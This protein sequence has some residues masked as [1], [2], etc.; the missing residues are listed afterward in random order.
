MP[1]FTVIIPTYNRYE[2][3][4]SA[5]DSVLLQTYKDFELIV[6]DDGSDDSTP[7]LESE[8]HSLLRYIRQSNHGVSSARNTGIVQS[9]SPYIAFLDSDDLWLPKKLQE[10]R[11]FIE[12]NPDIYIHQTNEMW[13]KNGRRVNPMEKHAKDCGDIFLKSLEMCMI[14]PSSVVIKRELLETY[15]LFDEN[16]PVCEDYDLW[17]RITYRENIGLIKKNLIKKFGGHESQL[18]RS[19][20]GMDRFRV[21]SIIKLLKNEGKSIKPEYY[22]EARN[23][24]LAKCRIL[25][26]GAMKRRNLKFAGNI[27]GIIDCLEAEDYSN[28]NLKILLEK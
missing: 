5:I 11:K 12:E 21:Y 4:K 14:S 23:T 1:L 8:Y 26:N 9:A 27:S 17:L 19:F 16:L 10:Q 2:T 20:W 7:L 18:S 6:V 13:I 28:I 3:L 25:F 22:L 24:A 15:D